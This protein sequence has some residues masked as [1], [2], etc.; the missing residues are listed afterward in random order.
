MGLV[1]LFFVSLSVLFF[2]GI[3]LKRGIN[4]TDNILIFSCPREAKQVIGRSSTDQYFNEKVGMMRF[5][6]RKSAQKVL[7][8]IKMNKE[9]FK[10]K[11]I[12]LKMLK[13]SGLRFLIDRNLGNKNQ[14]YSEVVLGKDCHYYIFKRIGEPIKVAIKPDVSV[15]VPTRTK[16]E[17]KNQDNP[18]NAYTAYARES[19]MKNDQ[20]IASINQMDQQS[21]IDMQNLEN[22]F[23]IGLGVYIGYQYNQTVIQQ[24]NYRNQQVQQQSF[25][26]AQRQALFQAQQKATYISPPASQ[27]N[28]QLVTNTDTTSKT[29]NDIDRYY[30]DRLTQVLRQGTAAGQSLETSSDIRKMYDEVNRQWAEAK[31][32]QF[33]TPNPQIQPQNNYLGRNL[34]TY[35]EKTA[36]IFAA[37]STGR[38]SF[39]INNHD[40]D[41]VGGKRIN[42]GSGSAGADIKN[43]QILFDKGSDASFSA[44]GRLV[45]FG[46]GTEATVNKDEIDFGNGKTC[47][48]F[49][50]EIK[51]N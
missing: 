8:E 47:S 44:F 31:A 27:I 41:Y 7:D 42:F 24:N 35:E 23:A 2:K 13:D 46:D 11:E 25:L 33:L 16:I 48:I 10:G 15:N 3:F 18:E 17:N 39:S 51:C 14:Q 43:R 6:E 9:A 37:Q 45:N 26:D 50:G 38:G 30:Q 5:N 34:P 1:I 19:Q 28:R 32:N 20:M 21:D 22:F 49:A 4:S 40:V 29:M 12:S 36:A